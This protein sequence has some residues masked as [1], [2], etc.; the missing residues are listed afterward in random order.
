MGFVVF[1]LI[2]VSIIAMIRASIVDS[3]YAKDK[4]I[5]IIVRAKDKE[6]TAD[7]EYF[8]A[9]Q[10]KIVDMNLM[11]EYG[12]RT[13]IKETLAWMKYQNKTYF[14]DPE[15][16]LEEYLSSYFIYG[17][18]LL[19]PAIEHLRTLSAPDMPENYIEDLM[20]E[21]KERLDAK[22]FVIKS[23]RFKLIKSHDAV[24]KEFIQ[25]IN[26]RNGLTIDNIDEMTGIEFEH[27]LCK[28]FN[29][30]GYNA[31]L[32]KASNDQGAD[33]ILEKNGER[34]VVQAKRYFSA[35]SNTAIQEVVAAKAFYKCEQCMV[36]TNSYFTKSAIILAMSN[37]VT[38]YDR[39]KLKEKLE[40]YNLKVL[41]DT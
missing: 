4:N 18:N 12:F 31:T 1:I 19:L 38:L 32:T 7:E 20:E 40:D 26:L 30:D 16:L 14:T 17:G 10:K 29:E 24:S 39:E 15:K 35:V 3:D 27:F 25:E 6:K 5:K 41:E 13:P 11:D 34:I 28:L 9:I 8:D 36:V 22:L 21:F 23:K 2:I 37:K 33:L